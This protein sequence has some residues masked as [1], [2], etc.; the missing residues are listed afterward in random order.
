MRCALI[1]A[2]VLAIVLVAGRAAADAS[3]IPDDV[4]ATAKRGIAGR[5]TLS[6]DGP[7]LTERPDQALSAPI[8]VKLAPG[9]DART[10]DVTFIG[11]VEGVYDLATLLQDTDGR[12]VTDLPPVRVRVISDLPAGHGTDVFGGVFG[13]T[14][15]RGGYRAALVGGAVAWLAIP[16]VVFLVRRFRAAPPV[17]VDDVLR[18]P[19][20]ADQLRPLVERA[21]RQTLTVDEQ[22]RLE[23]LLYRHWRE[24]LHLSEHDTPGA[25]QVLR[26]HRAAGALLRAMED[27]LHRRMP[28][29]LA[30][31]DVAC[32]L[33]P[34]EEALAVRDTPEGTDP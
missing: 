26:R 34:Y 33:R 32:L 2:G 11:T 16:V 22:G 21:A 10:Y 20:L 24:R 13:V 1:L 9:A 25:M 30:P 29:D 5:F 15:I 12:P 3:P 7:A 6:H 19:T 27:W 17:L 8:L 28:R 14:T 18:A 23:L 31:G 4:M